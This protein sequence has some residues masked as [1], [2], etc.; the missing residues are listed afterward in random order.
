MFIRVIGIGSLGAESSLSM[1]SG[2]YRYLS[3]STKKPVA[4]TALTISEHMHDR[5]NTNAPL[6]HHPISTTKP[7]FKR[8]SPETLHALLQFIQ[9][10]QP[11]QHNLLAGLL[12]LTRQKHLIQD[13]INLVQYQPFLLPRKPCP[14]YLVEIK[15][16]IQLTDIPKETIQHLDEKMYRL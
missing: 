14:I 1:F 6:T 3:S 13:R 12:D 2:M 16:Q 4:L 15:H 11:C 9:M 8:L 10:L 7:S 5:N